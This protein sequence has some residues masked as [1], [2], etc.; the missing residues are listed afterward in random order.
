MKKFLVLMVA[1]LCATLAQA[2]AVSSVKEAGKATAE[3]VKEGAQNVAAAGSSEPDKTI[4][5]AKAKVHKAKAHAHA[6]AAKA[7]AKAA[8]N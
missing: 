1:V 4:H 6:R 3:T 2:Q 8:T 7:D 5:K